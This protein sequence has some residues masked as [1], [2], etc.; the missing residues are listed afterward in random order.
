MIASQDSLDVLRSRISGLLSQFRTLTDPA[1]PGGALIGAMSEVESR[2]DSGAVRSGAR[3]LA[4]AVDELQAQLHDALTQVEKFDP[5]QRPDV[6]GSNE[7][8]SELNRALYE[9]SVRSPD[10]VLSVWLRSFADAFAMWQLD[11]C[12]RLT[13]EVDPVT[14]ELKDLQQ[15][16]A[17][18]VKALRDGD[19]AA[20]APGVELLA[21]ER[22]AG[23]PQS[24]LDQPSTAAVFVVLGRIRLRHTGDHAGAL[25]CFEKAGA[26]T[27]SD[28]RVHAA[29]SEYYGA[30]KED[31]RV[32][33]LNRQ[34]IATSRDRPDG[35]VGMALSCE[36]QDWWE[37]AQ[38]WYAQA[39]D[40]VLR[41]SVSRD[42]LSELGQWLAPVSGALYLR[43][44]QAIGTAN[45]TAGLAAVDEA[46]K[47]GVRGQGKY[48]QRAAY[49][50]KAELLESLKRP[51]EAADA[52]FQA[53][54]YYSWENNVGVA[55]QLY[56]R[57]N[58]LD[59]QHIGN[60]WGW[61]DALL[62]ASY[63][64]TPPY[65]DRDK[66]EQS[67]D[68]WTRAVGME[69]PDE[70]Y[71][72]AY[73][74]RA[75]IAQQL[76]SLPD[77]DRWERHWETAAFAEQSGLL[78]PVRTYSWLILGRIHHALGNDLNALHATETAVLCDPN[79][80]GAIEQRLIVLVNMDRYADAW[81]LVRKLS[82]MGPNWA[83]WLK[84]IEA[85][86]LLR[87]AR[88]ETGAPGYDEALAASDAARA[89]GWDA[90]WSSIDRARLLRLL[91]RAD[92]AREE[93]EKL[94]SKFDKKDVD[95]QLNSAWAA[96]MIGKYN[97]ALDILG[98]RSDDRISGLAA[99]QR[100]FGFC[101]L[102]RGELASA[103]KHFERAIELADSVRELEVWLIQDFQAAEV[104]Q[105]LAGQPHEGEAKQI[106]DQCKAS[107][108]KH[109]A[110]LR[111][112]S[113]PLQEMQWLIAK[114]E[115]K[116]ETAGWTWIAAHAAVARLNLEAR[117]WRA[118]E[119][120]YR[121]L[122]DHPGRF[123]VSP[124]GLEQALYGFAA[125]NT[126]PEN[127]ARLAGIHDQRAN[128]ERRR[129]LTRL[130]GQTGVQRLPTVTPIVIEAAENLKSL[131]LRDD[132]NLE[133][134]FA[135]Q[136]N[137]LR[138]GLDDLLG[139][140]LPS[141]YVRI[142]R[143]DLPDGTYIVIVN[144]VPLVSGNIDLTRGLCNE[145]VD[146][147]KLLGVKG[148]EAV[149]PV[150]G[151]ECAWVDQGDWQKLKDAGLSIWTPA[152]YIVLHLSAV[153]RK[154]SAELVGMQAVSNLL[155]ARTRTAEQYSSVLSAKGGL[156]R[157][158][159][160][161]QALLMEE[162]PVKELSSICDC[163][164]LNQDLPTHEIPDEIRCLE[165]VRKGIP[166]NTADTP[167]YRLGKSLISL[168]LRGIQRDGEAAVLALEPER[169]QDALTAVRKEVANLPRTTR[170]PVLFVEDWRMRSF[171]R[172]LV[173]LEFPYL[174]VLSRREAFAPDSRPVLATIEI[175]SRPKK[176]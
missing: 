76:A 17:L 134:Q 78:D 36:A 83:A 49:Q 163:Y 45:P 125:E 122:R 18:A 10:A 115:E 136:L 53:G 50:L 97:A 96:L 4:K 84:A 94:W 157:F 167:I 95:N 43:L 15:T 21:D 9:T 104:L 99:V 37:E 31:A 77:A 6:L 165:A 81:P 70:S 147:L 161:I 40:V 29:L 8:W 33:D 42:P 154:N 172:K 98:P 2:G 65:V 143:P 106:L 105:L 41:R 3:V 14:P 48:P 137:L 75:L 108:A 39:V 67:I 107:A 22:P 79:D 120:H 131:L 55:C 26:A 111:S 91:G 34:A 148:E 54:Q 160:V 155:K 132:G 146:G 153:A 64:S 126:P 123:Y 102:L 139:F 121:R 112:P 61:A 80:G 103:R 51:G 32:R 109:R 93:Y 1:G 82:T 174:A 133:P 46:I 7:Y 71:R 56:E 87:E 60:H 171:V 173:E 150:N 30:K 86:I 119:E 72:W 114:L 73:L 166:G 152:Q 162:V 118:A 66:I 20:A 19:H 159:S 176:R 57:A 52:F 24:P 44:A 149:N 168:I 138:L 169:T 113:S 12:E 170:N 23:L 92:Q 16:L 69:L 85:H 47:L 90:P 135:Q 164:V 35:Y 101:R 74:T 130:F 110:A 142:N 129:P 151:S 88:P 156:S 38:D 145:T 140:E 128:I 124:R 127:G 141:P 144:E 28:G 62:R 116:K 5:T 25:A 13:R 11:V 117:R 63:A 27:P 89:A 100:W 158:T 175:E 58:A 68:V 59:P